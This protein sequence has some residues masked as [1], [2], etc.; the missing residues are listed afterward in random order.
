MRRK[1]FVSYADQSVI[2]TTL[3][4]FITSRH[5]T[6]WHGRPPAALPLTPLHPLRARRV[7]AT[8]YDQTPKSS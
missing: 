8:G 5:A 1:S 4:N 2:E 7:S 6:V 3:T